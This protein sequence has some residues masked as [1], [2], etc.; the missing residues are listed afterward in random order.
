MRRPL[1]K[2]CNSLLYA[3]FVKMW[4]SWMLRQKMQHYA[5]PN[6]SNGSFDPFKAL[7]KLMKESPGLSNQEES[8]LSDCPHCN[9][10]AEVTGKYVMMSPNMCVE[11]VKLTCVI[12]HDFIPQ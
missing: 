8:V 3:R 12:G 9:L 11:Y 7:I 5:V 6:V 1:W 2:L 4:F 10:P